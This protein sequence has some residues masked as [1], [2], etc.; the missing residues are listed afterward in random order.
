MREILADREEHGLF[1]VG[2]DQATDM[3]ETGAMEVLRKHH[4]QNRLAEETEDK[5]V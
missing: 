2:L 4:M 3:D 1:G 5:A